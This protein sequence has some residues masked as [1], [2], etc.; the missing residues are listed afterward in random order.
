MLR[1]IRHWRARAGTLLAVACVL[2]IGALPGCA[3]DHA[4]RTPNADSAIPL[5]LGRIQSSSRSGVTVSVAVP[6][7]D[8]VVGQFGVT[9]AEYRIQ[10]IWVRIEN[11]SKVDDWLLPIAID[12]DYY[13]ADE[14]VLVITKNPGDENVARAAEHFRRRALPFFLRAESVNEGFKY[15]THQRGGRFVD[16]RLS[17]R[18]QGLRMRFAVMLPTEGF[19]YESSELRQRYARREALPN[20]SLEQTRATLRELPCCTS[21]EDG[22][23]EGDPLNIALVGS[24][25]DVI[26]ALVA[27]GWNLT[28]AIT[29]DSIRRMIGA[30]IADESFVTADQRALRVRPQA[31]HRDATFPLQRLPA[32]SHEALTRSVPLRRAARLGRAGKPRHRGQGDHPVADADH[33]RDR[34]ECRRITRVSLA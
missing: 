7:E 33:S 4:L 18:G 11:A 30:A 19:D 22:Q 23:G 15:A 10:P 29:I 32:N 26:S 27:G 24:G 1:A 3:T 20:L 25:E 17:G 14:V 16:L 8:E 2:L 13:T 12:P 28:E 34:S 6:D 21:R 9:L 31:G 5:R